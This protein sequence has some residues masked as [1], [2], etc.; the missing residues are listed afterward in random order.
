MLK[1][2]GCKGNWNDV[3]CDRCGVAL[4]GHVVNAETE[5]STLEREGWLCLPNDIDL[6]PIT[7]TSRRFATQNRGRHFCNNCR[8]AVILFI[9][10]GALS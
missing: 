4:I 6:K 3:S 1:P 5:R 7:L 9:L 2:N 8:Q 10:K